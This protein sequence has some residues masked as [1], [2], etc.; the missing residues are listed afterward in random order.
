[1]RAVLSRAYY[2]TGEGNRLTPRGAVSLLLKAAAVGLSVYISWYA[3]Y[4]VTN[5]HFH[6][7]VFLL[8]MLPVIFL[9]T[10]ASR[11]IE[12]IT[13]VDYGLAV[14]SAAISLYYILNDQ[15]YR[16]LIEGVTS[17]PDREIAIG[18]VLVVLSV[19]ACRRTVGWGLTG[20][21]VILFAYVFLG[22]L[23]EGELH[24]DPI[25][26]PYFIQLQTVLSVDG[27]FGT[28]LEVAATYAFLFVL[29]GSFYQRAGGG[30]FFFE[31]STALCGRAVGGPAKACVVSSA[32]YGSISGSPTADVVTT[33]PITI[34]LMVRMGMTTRR[35]A[36]IEAAASSGGALLPPVMGTVAFL[37]VGFTGLPYASIIQAGA[38]V[39]ILYY[40]GVFLAV[41]F[42]AKRSNQS[43]ISEDEIFSVASAIRRGWRQ[44]LPIAGL[45]YFLV[46]GYTPTY[47]AAGGTLFV[48]LLSWLNR[49]AET[50]I[51]P[52]NFIESCM[53][54]VFRMAALTGA[55]LAAGAIIGAV[56]MTGLPGKFTLMVNYVSAGNIVIVL[57]ATAL[58]VI[59]LGMGTP[60]V[61]SYIMGV[62]LLAP[63]LM[64][65]FGVS[66]L[67]TH[68]FLLYF[69]CMSAI[70][71][72]LA[73]ACFA[74]AAIAQVNP[75]S[76]A[77]Y[78]VKIGFA[79]FVLPF[80]FIFNP[81]LLMI[82]STF[83]IVTAVIAG[84]GLVL[85][86]LIGML[87]TIGQS[88]LPLPIRLPFVA[89]AFAMIYPLNWLQLTLT[90]IVVLAY[91][92][93]LRGPMVKWLGD[94]E[95]RGQSSRVR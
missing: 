90:A 89:A 20:V 22:H 49:Q 34:P 11:A 50:R 81:G 2:L 12:R 33:G 47:V 73:T 41:H 32:L 24:H 54:T 5:T 37:M 42:E 59:L 75:I 67:Q 93:A 66:L 14:L 74:A 63:V 70:T 29:F 88:R 43:Q 53:E 36:A 64:V 56:E 65:D 3:F 19:E 87:G 35:A 72:P 1:M 52:F 57:I 61:S 26:L 94:W 38:L 76:I 48:V 28:P 92:A 30:Q 23:L 91:F 4:G 77:M 39:A 80:F 10:T 27:I 31:I 85:A 46:E 71:P 17:I 83:D 69:S 16:T 84:C 8:V 6:G 55:V 44:L 78:A 86:S 45:L 79:G 60:A 68:M 95:H 58:V 82:G 51:G 40:V 9:T 18:L 62:A 21:L 25:D 13:R 15:F 7:A